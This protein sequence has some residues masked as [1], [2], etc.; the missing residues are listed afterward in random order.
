MDYG[1]KSILS[2]SEEKCCMNL[3]AYLDRIGYHGALDPTLA[4]L[5]AL[6]RTHLLSIPYEN[7]DIHLGS[8]L[9]VDPEK[10]FDKIVTRHR[11]GWCYEMN[12]LF[13]WALREIG[14]DVTLMSSDVRDEFVGDGSAGDHLVLRVMLDQR[15]YLVDVGFGN[16]I[17]EPIPLEAGQYQ[18]GYLNYHLLNEGERW[19][20]QNHQYGGPGFVFTLQPHT[21]SDFTRRCDELQTLPDSGFVRATVCFRFTPQGY[22]CLRGAVLTTV[23]EQGTSEQSVE[24]SATYEQVLNSQFDLHFLSEQIEALWEKVWARH[25]LWLQ[26]K[27]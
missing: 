27:A 12:G 3:D 16:G 1:L 19:F 2:Q 17:L 5:T 24:N 14:F 11:G 13:S 25:Q 10:I 15:P 22:I 8:Y 4:T 18:Q 26:E 21:L 9:S 20:F 7:L 6:H 23:T